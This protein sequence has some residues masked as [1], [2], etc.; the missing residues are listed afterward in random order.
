LR[1]VHARH[2]FPRE[3]MS[4]R[5][6]VARPF[7]DAVLATL[8]LEPEG[9]LRVTAGVRSSPE[10]LELFLPTSRR[11]GPRARLR[12]RRPGPSSAPP[13]GLD[14]EFDPG[15]GAWASLRLDGRARPVDEVQV[16]GQHM[17][18]WTHG[19]DPNDRLMTRSNARQRLQALGVT[20]VG[21]ARL[22][23][24]LALG[25]V[26][27]GVRNLTLVDGDV[28]EDHSLDALECFPE[29]VGQH[30]V[31][32]LANYLAEVFPAV[33]VRAVAE[34][35]E[36]P[37]AFEACAGADLIVSAPDDNRARLAAALAASAH[38]RPHLDLGSGVFFAEGRRTAGAD[39]R[40][41]LPGLGCLLCAGGLDLS[42]R[43]TSDWRRQRAGSLRSLNQMA[44]GQAVALVQRLLS[45]GLSESVW[46]R[47]STGQDGVLS[48][49]EMPW[50]FEPEC[51]LCARNSG[52][53]DGA[54][55]NNF[56]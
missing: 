7:L 52:A 43:P 28:L 16:C 44:A 40:L 55:P 50:T 15:G 46:I 14:L 49:E 42:R 36:S 2:S 30:K 9:T 37:A 32:A 18:R 56:Q 29:A 5:V 33:Q 27:L 25:L 26:R 21:S 45:G 51:R 10:R 12:L 47:L 35:V 39:V 4:V 48:C 8:A 38:L 17:E 20:L 22:G 41:M 19:A 53:G 3:N 13:T 34:P 6:V 31:H 24:A 54:F 1:Q 23:S 11:A